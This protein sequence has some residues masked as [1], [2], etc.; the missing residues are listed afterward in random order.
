[1]LLEEPTSKEE[2]R[3]RHRQCYHQLT[4]AGEQEREGRDETR[5]SDSRAKP[6][7][8]RNRSELVS[9]P[10]SPPLTPILLCLV[11]LRRTCQQRGVENPTQTIL[12]PT[13]CAGEQEGERKERGLEEKREIEQKTK[14]RRKGKR[15]FSSLFLPIL[16]RCLTLHY[17]FFPPDDLPRAHTPSSFL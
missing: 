1:L 17:L 5:R 9:F 12:S 11:A 8:E 2:S 3:I 16:A 13:N 4:W 10:S 7:K 15:T 14:W 6:E